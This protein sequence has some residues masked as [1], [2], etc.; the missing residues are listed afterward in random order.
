MAVALTVTPA[1]CLLLLGKPPIKHHE[2]PLMHWLKGLYRPVL[3]AIIQRPRPVF[4]TT[5]VVMLAGLIVLPQLGESLLPEFQERDFLMHW[6][7]KPGSAR[8]EAHRMTM[9]ASR[10]RRA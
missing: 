9:Q 1:L 3:A 7:T 5:A 6:I 4:A 8:A 2:P 10:E